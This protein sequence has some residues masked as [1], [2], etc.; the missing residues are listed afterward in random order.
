METKDL[1]GKIAVVTGGTQGLGEAISHL[2]AG[3]G[4]SGLVICG[5]NRTNGEA[6]AAEI[7]AIG[8]R[9][10]FQYADLSNIAD[11]HSVIATADRQF[12]RVDVLV[13]AAG[14]TDRS[15]ILDTS[16]ARF[17]ELFSVNVKAPF[18]LIQDAAQ[19]MKREGI[20]GSIINIQSMAA[21]G[22]APFISAYSVSKGALATLTKNAAHSLLR[23]K[24]RVNGLNV[25][26]MATPGEDRVMRT[27]HGAEDGWLEEAAKSR[28]FGRLIDPREIARA[29]LYLASDESGLMTGANIDFDQG[30]V[31]TTGR[32]LAL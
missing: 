32:P 9:T 14:L 7:S 31:G 24:I 3:R 1:A 11:V 20:H 29:C 27:Y 13:N 25:G 10:V 21:Y 4:V 15:T 23:Y 19:V 28:P 26:W 12:G 17:D 6:V 2:F 5:R 8:C 22:G 30:V 18:F 16:E